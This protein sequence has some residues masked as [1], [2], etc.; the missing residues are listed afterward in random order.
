MDEGLEVG[1]EVEQWVYPATGAPAWTF[2]ADDPARE[3]AAP[4]WDASDER[5]LVVV[6]GDDPPTRLGPVDGARAVAQW[7][8]AGSARSSREQCDNA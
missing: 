4:T 1:F 3:V 2:I 6:S 8:E 5:V 7:R